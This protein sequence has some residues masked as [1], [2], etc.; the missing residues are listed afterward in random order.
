[1][2]EAVVARG[3][4]RVRGK[5]ALRADFFNVFAI[6]GGPPRFDGFFAQ[7]LERKQRARPS[8]MW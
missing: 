6:D 7:Q 5:H 8:F 3:H 2:G 4:R 1:M